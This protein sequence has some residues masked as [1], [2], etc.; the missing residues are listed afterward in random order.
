VVPRGDPGLIPPLGLLAQPYRGIR[1]EPQ[2]VEPIPRPGMVQLSSPILRVV[3]APATGVASALSKDEARPL[4]GHH[5]IRFQGRTAARVI[6][7]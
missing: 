2:P 5:T 4:S 7:M 6:P 3:T 1:G